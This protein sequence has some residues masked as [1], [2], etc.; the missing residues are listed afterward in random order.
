MRL[1]TWN[2]NG[3]R[4]AIRKGLDEWMEDIDA[5]VWLFQE[6]RA[7]PEQLPKDWKLPDGHEVLWHPAEKK[8]YSGV[9]TFSRLGIEEISRG[10]GTN[11][12]PSDS[13][14]R[15]LTTKCGPIVCI[16][17]Y[18]PNGA[19]RQSYKDRWLEDLLVWA[20][21]YLNSPEP[22]VLVGD[23]NIAHT[24]ADIWNPS[25]NRMTSG[26]LD[27]EREWF[28]R[29]LASGWHD[30]HRI[31]FGDQK[32]PYTWWSNRGQ[33]RALD[34]GWRIDYV[35]ANNAAYS[36]FESAEVNRQAGLACSDHAPLIIDFDI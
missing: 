16:N 19:R 21:D 11:L 30:L 4:A 24:E 14:G 32:G 12:D 28:D 17:I 35:L 26:F 20:K 18:L 9:A 13:E 10:I 3:I 34:R 15:V 23:L 31:H 27:H 36:I 8:G 1:V 6:V 33:A 25:G 5:D 7:L 2:L 29:F 22:V